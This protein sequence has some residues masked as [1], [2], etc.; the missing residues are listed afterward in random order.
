LSF[1]TGYGVELAILVDTLA[2]AG[3]DA[4][5]QVDLGERVHRHH[6]DARLGLM[7][8]EIL[9]VALARAATPGRGHDTSS[10]APALNP[11]LV[12]FVRP[13]DDRVAGLPFDVVTTDVGLVERPPMVTLAEYTAARGERAS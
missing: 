8:S 4:I 13:T 11:T 6:D 12:Q 2:V 3:L 9:Q 5:A 10:T 1:P 7:A